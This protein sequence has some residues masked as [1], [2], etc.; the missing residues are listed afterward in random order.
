ME[1]NMTGFRVL[2]AALGVAAVLVAGAASAGPDVKE[3][4]FTTNDGYRLHYIEAGKGKPIVMIPG[5]SQTAAQWKHQME[6]ADQ[7]HVIALDMRGHGESSK[8]DYGYRMHRL[9]KDVYDFIVARNLRDVTLMGHSMGASVMWGYWDLYRNERLAK[10]IVV[11]QVPACANNPAWTEVQKNEA[12]GMMGP[13]Q[14]YDLGNKIAGSDEAFTAGLLGG[15]FT[16]AYSRDELAWVVQENLKFPREPAARLVLHH[17]FTDWR[18]LFKT[19]NVPT[20]IFGGK[21]S[22]FKVSALEWM[23]TQIPGSKLVVFTE[24]EGGAHFMFME[25]PAKF[26]PIIRDFVR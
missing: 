23:Q 13:D 14:W 8:G 12:G 24:E 26:N 11:D 17:C 16:K 6:L 19:I 25:N 18:D 20:L 2:L 1:T 10:M 7:Y 15:M 21:V 22:F 5:W 9:S 4:Y 3:G